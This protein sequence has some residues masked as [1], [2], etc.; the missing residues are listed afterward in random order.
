MANGVQTGWTKAQVNA[1]VAAF[2]GWT[3]DA[4]DFFLMVFVFVDI[5]KEFNTTIP[6][7]AWAT[8]LTLAARFIGAYIFGR[9]ADAYGRRPVLMIVILSYSFFAF[10]SGLS[11]NLATLL[12][13]RTLFGIAMGANGG[14]APRSSWRLSRRGRA[15]SFPVFC[16]AA[17]RRAIS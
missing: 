13:L 11:P 8:T 16:N 5:A 10:V 9:A 6:T 14:W 15:A 3:L 2:L 12:V 7:V 17:I 1:V 4:F